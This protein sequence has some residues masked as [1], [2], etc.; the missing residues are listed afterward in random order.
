MKTIRLL[1]GTSSNGNPV[2]EEILVTDLGGSRFRLLRSPGLV[3][4]I[5]R[6]DEIQYDLNSGTFHLLQRGGRVTV[7]IYLGAV[8][9]AEVQRLATQLEQVASAT[10]DGFSERQ[11]IFSFPVGKGFK[12]VE[13]LL[14]GFVEMRP[15]TEWYYGNIYAD[16]GI[17][18]LNWWLD[19]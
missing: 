2:F 14:N 15:G 4:G 17:S 16:D 9:Q 8:D 12:V 13:D 18:P 10:W 5:A 6:D 19:T 7:Q 11:A 1:A 3:Q